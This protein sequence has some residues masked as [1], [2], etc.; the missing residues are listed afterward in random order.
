MTRG[1]SSL[2]LALAVTLTAAGASAHSAAGANTRASTASAQSAVGA[3]T[4]AGA[5]SAQSADTT[6][7]RT[8]SGASTRQKAH[9]FGADAGILVPFHSYYT[10]V[11]VGGVFKYEVDPTASVGITGRIGYLYGP[12]SPKHGFSDLPIWLGVRYY[13]TGGGEGLHAGVEFGLNELIVRDVD[14]KGQ[15]KTLAGAAWGANIP[16]GYK[17]GAVDI[18][19]QLSMFSVTVPG[20]LA[21][22]ITVGYDLA[23]Y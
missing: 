19:A 17:V 11:L 18:Q 7:T 23:R 20:A 12:G 16:I 14:Y 22:G 15:P 8:A 3:N 10:H 6:S 2:G 5:A 13:P 9:A 21:A 4:R 1:F